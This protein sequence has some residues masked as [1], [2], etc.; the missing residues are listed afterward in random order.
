MNGTI[1]TLIVEDEPLIIGLYKNIF[2]ELSDSNSSFKLHI[3]LNCDS[4]LDKIEK[5][6][7]GTPFDL[8]LL[9]INIPPSK[10]KNISSGED[11]GVELR[12]CFPQIK[13]IICTTTNSN[14]RLNNIL[15]TVNPDGFLIKSETDYKIL[16]TAINRVL[17]NQPYYSPS[18]FNLMRQHICND[19]VLNSK[20]RIL[21]YELSKGTKNKD[22]PNFV[23]LSKSGFE[24]RKR[25]LKEIFNVEGV[26]D[27]KLIQTSRENGYV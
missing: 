12:K 23:N 21:L 27:K 26:G 19:F 18:I 20:D 24:A 17:T 2:Q 11:L 25:R 7:T 6:N 22:L 15:H 4:A 9:D 16:A 14:Y 1:N 8:V 5:A 3:T 13:I 10:Q